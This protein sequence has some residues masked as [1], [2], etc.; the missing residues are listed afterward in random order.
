MSD[1]L[2]D[3]ALVEFTARDLD[4][5]SAKV[6]RTCD[7]EGQVVIHHR[8]G[9]SYSLKRLD[10]EGDNTVELP[11]FRKRMEDAGMPEI[12]IEISKAVDELISGGK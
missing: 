8:D 11:D 3:M 4:R 9:R 2:S 10:V 5:S 7:E 6:L 1:L 12:P